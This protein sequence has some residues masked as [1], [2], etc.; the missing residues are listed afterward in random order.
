MD[1]IE[2]LNAAG[3]Q[4]LVA[5]LESLS[6]DARKNLEK[7][8]ESQDWAELKALYT[9]KS[10]ASLDDNVTG[11]LKPMPFKTATDDL[12][13]DFWKET[14]EILLDRLPRGMLPPGPC[15]AKFRP[16]LSKNRNAN[17]RLRS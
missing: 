13:Y 10:N 9:E 5:K 6:G 15:Q 4:E 8:I 17:H 3:Q 14:G 12:R 11:D 2:T 16:S 1:I 7:D